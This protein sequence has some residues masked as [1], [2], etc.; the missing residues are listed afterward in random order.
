LT[1]LVALA[2]ATLP[3]VQETTLDRTVL[4]FTFLISVAT[5]IGFG[6]FPAFQISRSNLHDSLKESAR[7]SSGG[8]ERHRAR[9]VLVVSEVALTIVVLIGAGLMIESLGRL[10]GVNPGF[11]TQH[12]LT[13]QFNLPQVR[14]PNDQA[15]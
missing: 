5:G 7:G 4:I 10:R 11:D 13:A 2:P 8:T 12:V 9:A 14:Y 1:A 3:R 6:V 15:Q